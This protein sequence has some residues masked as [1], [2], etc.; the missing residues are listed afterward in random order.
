M[1][2]T[3]THLR[4]ALA[5]LSA[6]A[7]ALVIGA[8]AI[9][10]IDPDL[11]SPAYAPQKVQYAGRPVVGLVLGSGASRGFAHIGVIQTLEANGIVPDVVVGTS[12][13]SLV[14]ALYAGGHDGKALEK[15][16]LEMSEHDV[17]D[18]MFPDRGFVRG[19]ALQAFVNRHLGSRSIEQ[20]D[21]PFAA[22]ATDLSEGVPIAF[23]RGNAGI[24]VRASSSIPG[25]FQPARIGGKDYV[26]G[27]LASPVPIETARRLGADIVIAV[28]VSRQPDPDLVLDNIIEILDQ[29]ISIMGRYIA[30]REAGQADILIQPDLRTI[31][32]FDFKHVERAINAGQVAAERALPLIRDVIREKLAR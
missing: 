8:C 12:S 17:R 13:G 19:N 15:I 9:I 22:V 24:A 10:P 2:F 26:D 31:G 30:A 20:L 18:F 25:V 32:R 5:R 11:A 23:N 1:E 21:K 7:I 3:M 4:F 6:G 27:G 16:A 29:T 14:G 28:D